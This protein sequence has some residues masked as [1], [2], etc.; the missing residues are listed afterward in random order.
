M[1]NKDR[2]HDQEPL[3][4]QVYPHRESDNAEDYDTIEIL[5]EDIDEAGDSSRDSIP[6][7]GS[8]PHIRVYNSGCGCGCLPFIGFLLLFYLLSK[9]F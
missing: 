6:P 2:H 3:E 1:D 8:I 7:R 9:L 5:P 4:I